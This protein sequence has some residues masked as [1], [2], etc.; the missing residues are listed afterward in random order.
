IL[1]SAVPG[2]FSAGADLAELGTLP[3]DPPARGAFRRT[4]AEGIEAIAALP[5]P[6]IAAVD[7]GC[8]GAA[9]ALAI[10][11]DLRVAGDGAV[12]ATTPARLG[13][14]Y[15]GSDVARLIARIGQGQAA[16]ML[17]SADPIC[18][19]EAHRIGLAELRAPDAGAAARALAGRIAALAPGAVAQLKRTIADPLSPRVAPDFEAAFGAAEFAERLAA[20]R[21]RAR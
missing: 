12:F 14:G 1:A 3:N 20:F 5:M 8:Y 18:A 17:L 11:C 21:E 15:P 9:V 7:G 10:A 4:M 6:A 19:D 2:I 13:I 16:R